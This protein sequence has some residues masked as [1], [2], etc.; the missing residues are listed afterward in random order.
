MMERLRV[1]LDGRRCPWNNDD[2]RF[3]RGGLGCLDRGDQESEQLQHDQENL[4]VAEVELEE[5]R[6]GQADG[7]RHSRLGKLAPRTAPAASTFAK[8]KREQKN[9]GDDGADAALSP[10]LNDVVVQVGRAEAG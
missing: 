6:V 8:E 5:A 10:Q 7:D 9:V 2:L 4:G 1:G 3:I